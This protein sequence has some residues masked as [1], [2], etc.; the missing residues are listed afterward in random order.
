[1]NAWPRGSPDVVLLRRGPGEA[2]RS[3]LVVWE[4]AVHVL[5]LDGGA[6]LV[7]A[8]RVRRIRLPREVAEREPCVLGTVTEP[9]LEDRA[10][11]ARSVVSPSRCRRRC[12]PLRPRCPVVGASLVCRDERVAVQGRRPDTREPRAELRVLR[13]VVRLQVDQ[14]GGDHVGREVPRNGE[15]AT[16]GLRPDRA[17]DRVGGLRSVRG[18]PVRA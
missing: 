3:P 5:A 11:R 10:A 14:I 16:A 18:D 15:G 4:D 9:A 1:M 2:P 12:G 8:D 6:L 13:A 17:H 7:D